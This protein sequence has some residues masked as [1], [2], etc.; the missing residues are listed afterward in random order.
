MSR[1]DTILIYI[2]ESPQIYCL[3]AHVFAFLLTPCSSGPPNFGFLYL[4][5]LW[6]SPLSVLLSMAVNRAESSRKLVG[7][8]GEG[9][10]GNEAG[11][12]SKGK[13]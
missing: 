1:L 9:G 2:T 7:R 3:G 6:A 11:I 4:P 8:P 13:E 10:V 12:G 5:V